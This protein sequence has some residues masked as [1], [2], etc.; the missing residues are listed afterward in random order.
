M[1]VPV[2]ISSPKPVL[3]LLTGA[4]MPAKK[5]TS[6][7]PALARSSGGGVAALTTLPVKFN[8]ERPAI[9]SIKIGDLLRMISFFL[10]NETTDPGHCRI[11]RAS[12]T[13]GNAIEE[14]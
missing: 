7:L 5:L 11:F 13:Y 8:I 3:S 6:V 9:K 4:E 12:H 1:G 14:P 10:L 2:F